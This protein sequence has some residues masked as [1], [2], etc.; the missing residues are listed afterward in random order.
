MELAPFR[1]TGR[2]R[3]GVLQAG[4]GH[5][6][7]APYRAAGHTRPGEIPVVWCQMELAPYKTLFRLDLGVYDCLVDKRS[8]LHLR[9]VVA[10]PHGCVPHRGS[11]LSPTV[12]DPASTPTPHP[13][14]PRSLNHHVKRFTDESKRLRVARPTPKTRRNLE[15]RHAPNARAPHRMPKPAATRPNS[16]LANA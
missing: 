15:Q 13:C 8:E 4:W 10:I 3:P 9:V 5:M 1:A 11:A 16:A 2:D 7:L 12:K 6:E 14:C